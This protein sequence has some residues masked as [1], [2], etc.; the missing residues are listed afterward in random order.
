MNN[1]QRLNTIIGWTTF[2]LSAIVF[3]LTIEPTASWWDPGEFISTTY[4]LQIGH[5]PGAPT[6]QLIGRLFSLFAFGNVARVAMMINAM[7]A[8]CSALAVLFLFWV[9]TMFARKIVAP[10]GEMTKGRMWTIFAA[11]FIGA[12]TFAFTDSFWFSA[13]E[14]EV[15]AMSA[16]FTSLVFWA[17]MKWESVADQK[18]ASRWLIFIALMIGFAIGVH[19]LN[20]LTIPALGYVIYFKKF[21]R[22]RKGMILTLLISILVLAFIMYFVIPWIPNLAG[23]F[24]ILFVNSFHMPFQSGTIFYFALLIGLIIWGLWYTHRTNRPLINSIILAFAFLLMGYST[25][26]VLVIRANA[27]TPINEN[28]PKDIVGLVSYLNREQYGTFLR[29]VL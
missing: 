28:D 13:V 18:H 14:G 4:K 20:L 5:P 1:Y 29:P 23:K 26:L 22:T 27:D 21:K 3:L 2:A 24:E 12:M 10:N 19:L 9:I 16:M 8:I 25:F 17:I 6:M 15:Y 7:S 11:G